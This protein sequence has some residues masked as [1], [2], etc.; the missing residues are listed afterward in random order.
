[1]QQIHSPQDA[2]SRA[3]G[4]RRVLIVLVHQGDVIVDVFLLGEHAAQAVLHD[5]RDLVGVRWVVAYAIW[6][7]GRGNLTTPVF[8]L[9]PFPV[10]RSSPR[11]RAE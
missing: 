5:D 8:V 11:G 7:E 10:E 3:F 2:F 9:Q 1:M 4:H 6:N